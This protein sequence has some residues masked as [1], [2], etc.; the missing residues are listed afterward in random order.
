MIGR[1]VSEQLEQDS[2]VRLRPWVLHT[3]A[4]CDASS[5]ACPLYAC[6]LFL[7]QL[8]EVAPDRVVGRVR[9]DGA[10]RAQGGT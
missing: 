1:L 4:D 5:M 3:T 7:G 10:Q 6:F 9:L 2:G 8:E